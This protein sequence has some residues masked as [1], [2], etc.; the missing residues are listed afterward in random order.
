MGSHSWNRSKHFFIIIQKNYFQNPTL[1]FDFFLKNPG[2]FCVFTKPL[3]NCG[4]E[5]QRGISVSGDSL[6]WPHDDLW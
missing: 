2:L 6:V 4:G 3:K 1:R 5:P